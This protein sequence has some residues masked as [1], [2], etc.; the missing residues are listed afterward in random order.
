M[1]RTVIWL[2]TLSLATSA[3]IALTTNSYLLTCYFLCIMLLLIALRPPLSFFKSNNTTQQSGEKKLP[4]KFSVVISALIALCCSGLFITINQINPDNKASYLTLLSIVLWLISI[5]LP[6]SYYVPRKK[7]SLP[8]FSIYKNDLLVIGAITVIAGVLRLYNLSGIIQSHNDEFNFGGEI[9]KVLQGYYPNPFSIGW[10]D[11]PVL[12]SYLLSPLM[13]LF[14]RTL[15]A[16]RIAPAVIGTLTIPTLY[17][18][19]ITL[20]P[21]KK[22][23]AA[24]AAVSYALLPAGIAFSRL[25]LNN[26]FTTFFALVTLI[27]L[28]KTLQTQKTIYFLLTGYVAGFGLYFYFAS[29][30]VPIII[31]ITVI[32]WLV[33]QKPKIKITTILSKFSLMLFGFI[34]ISWPLFLSSY[35]VLGT[36]ENVIL[37][38]RAVGVKTVDF[39]KLY[40]T[41]DEK[42]ELTYGSNQVFTMFHA[43]TGDS[44][45]QWGYMNPILSEGSGIFF[46][47]GIIMCLVLITNTGL[48][49]VISTILLNM[50]I[51]GVLT[52][53][54]PFFPRLIIVFPFAC[55]LV[56]LGIDFVVEK[57]ELT[58]TQI[59]LSNLSKQVISL[60]IIVIVAICVVP[61]VSRFLQSAHIKS[62]TEN[63]F[64]KMKDLTSY[65]NKNKHN[66]Y[67]IF[68][69]HPNLG[70]T[71]Q[72][73][74]FLVPDLNDVGESVKETFS[75]LDQVKNHEKSDEKPFLTFL[76]EAGRAQTTK[77]NKIIPE[78]FPQ[79]IDD[80][81]IT[82]ENKAPFVYYYKIEN[83]NFK[84]HPQENN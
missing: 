17:I 66:S 63:S 77:E 13:L 23:V 52:E 15:L 83:P 60:L 33:F 48:F 20:F 55:I 84:Q 69:G 41:E 51:G 26:P 30:I 16:I 11:H 58:V 4:L 18:F 73:I 44:S 29:R 72:P 54:P 2:C 7:I 19:L 79:K 35:K 82:Y 50:I 80:G 43:P 8:Q 9:V 57:F 78:L 49:T 32:H 1:T 65:M 40:L 64:D 24:I 28:F 3:V 22:R 81:I 76:I 5:V 25:G 68:L 27:L 21:Q 47:I 36:W 71:F 12:F 14:G 38:R 10:Y 70:Y 31:I 56:A 74:N 61:D 34:L 75:S 6:L 42:A 53:S 37:S 46:L 45:I 67:Y 62:F 59:K 39:K